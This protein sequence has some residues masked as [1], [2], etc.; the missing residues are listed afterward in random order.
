MCDFTEYT[1]ERAARDAMTIQTSGN[2]LRK[3]ALTEVLTHA[4][5]IKTGMAMESSKAQAEKIEEKTVDER[6]SYVDKQK[7]YLKKR[8]DT[9][10]SKP[11]RSNK[12]SERKECD[13]CG[14]DP[15]TSHKLRQVSC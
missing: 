11:P 7:R 5:F 4:Q 2:H 15:R 1:A 8:L 12:A 9:F 14:Y 10:R 13:F 6:V 3:R